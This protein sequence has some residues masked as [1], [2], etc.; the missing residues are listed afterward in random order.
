MKIEEK[1]KYCD[2]I[3]SNTH[4][5]HIE[6]VHS[7]ASTI[8]LL[9]SRI[10]TSPNQLDTA[11]Y[12]SDHAKFTVIIFCALVSF[13]VLLS[14][15]L[16][17]RKNFVLFTLLFRIVHS[18]VWKECLL[19]LSIHV[20]EWASPVYWISVYTCFRRDGG[21]G[22]GSSSSSS[23]VSDSDGSG[24]DDVVGF[25]QSSSSSFS[26]SF[27]LLRI[28]FPVSHHSVHMLSMH[29]YVLSMSS[30]LALPQ[31]MQSTRYS[32]LILFRALCNRDSF[33]SD[34]R[35]KQQAIQSHTSNLEN[36]ICARLNDRFSFFSKRTVGGNFGFEVAQTIQ[37][38]FS[39]HSINSR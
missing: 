20:S 8:R 13:Y 14:L 33:V 10:F 38:N 28:I 17:T 39:F 7:S 3:K 23:S 24:D 30:A 22:S 18:L 27:T 21:G 6:R 15:A 29:I 36:Y 11:K 4:I 34:N 12:R 9:F 32:I 2:T 1:K 26:S 25:S 37:R 16:S 35:Y 5:A 31:P 19:F